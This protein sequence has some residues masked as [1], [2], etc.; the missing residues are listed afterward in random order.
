MRYVCDAGRKTWFEIETEADA[1]LESK[2]MNHAVEKHFRRLRDEAAASYQPP[3]RPLVEQNIG[4]NGHI[5]RAMPMFLTLRDAEGNGLA[6]AMLPRSG[7]SIAVTPL[8]VG[9][10]NTD[11][12]PEHGDAIHILGEQ[13]GLRLERALCF[14]YSRGR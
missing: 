6:T 12:Y 8:I 9:P 1:A 10:L 13:L 14:P 4:L 2:L 7:A 11:P 5:R 3:P